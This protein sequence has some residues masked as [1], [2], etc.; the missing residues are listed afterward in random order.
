MQRCDN[1]QTW[2]RKRDRPGNVH[3]ILARSRMTTSA[4]TCSYPTTSSALSVLRLLAASFFSLL[5]PSV[6]AALLAPYTFPLPSSSAPWLLFFVLLPSSSC[7]H[8]PTFPTLP[9]LSVLSP[10]FL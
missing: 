2:P 8:Q 1:K 7:S 9:S 6:S 5:P 4:S 3:I 10:P